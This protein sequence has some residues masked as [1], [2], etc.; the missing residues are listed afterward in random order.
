MNPFVFQAPTKHVFGEG[1]VDGVGAE[2][3]ASGWRKVLLVYGQGSA[4]RSG[5]ID[6]VRS[7]LAEAGVE[8]VE[9]A[10]VR[11]NPEVG[12]VR[13]GIAA[14][15]AAQA[16]AVLAVG[17]GSVIDTAKAIAFGAPYDGDV[18][19]FFS[20]KAAIG[21]C[22]PIAVVLT[23]PGAGSE[24]S[25]SCVISNDE[26][27]AKTSAAGDAFRPRVAFMDPALTCTLPPYQTAAGVTDMIAHICERF[28]SGAG[29]VP[30]T[31]QIACG[32]VRSLVG[33]APRVMEDP[34][35][36]DARANIMWAGTLAHN[37]IAGCGRALNP[38]GRAGG[39]E[40]HALEHAL[41]ALDTRITH[42]AGLAVVMPAWM[43]HVWRADPGRFLLFGREVFGIEPITEEDMEFT[44]PVDEET[45]VEWA[46]EATIDELSA[47]FQS[48]GMPATLG[49]L[50]I[51]EGDIDGLADA[52]IASKGG[53][54]G[55]FATL[56][57][58]DAAAIYRSAL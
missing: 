19:D 39:W 22:L 47:F 48:L 56:T 20:G 24:G 58:D 21:E 11:P 26:L 40:S 42:G 2:L 29:D 8:A 35:D 33:E 37:D 44:G 55:A 5:L 36:L 57:R 23:I 53:P 49:E 30:V 54:F 16:D 7:S 28:F 17:G 18:W 52:V 12:L 45:T 14:A 43:R 32:L 9:L 25:S 15:R 38:G 50:G 1:V 3:A 6:R 4:V 34:N 51:A 46:V 10:G 27:G 31:D 13:E 41:S